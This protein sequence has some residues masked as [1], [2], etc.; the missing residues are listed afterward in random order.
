MSWQ[1]GPDV[2]LNAKWS[3]GHTHCSL[4]RTTSHLH[5]KVQNK[6][7]AD[8]VQYR[9]IQSDLLS[10]CNPSVEHSA[11]RHLPAT[12]WLQDPS[13]QFPFI[14]APDYVL[15]LLLALH[16]FYLKLLYIVCCTA[17]SIHFCLFT[18]GAILLEFEL[19]LLSE[20]DEMRWFCRIRGSFNLTNR[21]ISIRRVWLNWNVRLYLRLRPTAY[22]DCRT[23]LRAWLGLT[24]R[25]RD[26]LADD[27]TPWDNRTVWECRFMIQSDSTTSLPVLW[28]GS[29][30]EPGEQSVGQ[31]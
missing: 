12:S 11:S 24:E 10:K 2:V 25:W 1:Q 18:R 28:W 15:F 29:V 16:C 3:C 22:V 7:C 23:R 14:W 26:D 4:P 9:H 31:T 21:N 17:L 8:L 13:Q 5:Q 30:I 20:D 19:A 27:R 6:I